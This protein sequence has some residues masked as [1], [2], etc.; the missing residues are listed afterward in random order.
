MVHDKGVHRFAVK[1]KKKSVSFFAFS[2]LFHQLSDVSFTFKKIHL[3]RWRRREDGPNVSGMSLR[4]HTLY[5]APPLVL[6]I[7]DEAWIMVH[8]AFRKLGSG[9]RRIV[10]IVILTLRDTK[11][12]DPSCH[13]SRFIA[14]SIRIRV[15]PRVLNRP[16]F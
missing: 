3:F 8:G 16:L 6:P 12:D 1:K 2:S 14:W 10:K 9:G 5:G 15:P 13:V 4:T 7:R 11:N